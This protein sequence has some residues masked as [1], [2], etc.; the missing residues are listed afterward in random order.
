[1]KRKSLLICIFSII[2]SIGKCFATDDMNANKTVTTSDA[3]QIVLNSFSD[4]EYDIFQLSS[5][6]RLYRFFIDFEPK[7]GWEHNCA[8]FYIFKTYTGI[9]P[10]SYIEYYSLPPNENRTPLRINSIESSFDINSLRFSDLDLSTFFNPVSKHT[11]AIIL[12]GG[13]NKY[14]NYERYWNDCS[15]IY[16]TLTQRYCIPKSN[17]KVLMADGQDPAEDMMKRGKFEFISSPLDLDFDDLNEIEFAATRTNLIQIMT[18]FQNTLT[19]DDHLF[20]FV[21]D[22]GARYNHDNG[23]SIILW[24]DERFYD[25]EMKE[26]LIPLL[27]NSVTV[28]M[29]LGQCFS[30]GF[31]D[32]CSMGG[33]TIATACDKDEKSDECPD[34]PFDEF[35]YQW[36]SAMNGMNVS[37][38]KV[39]SDFDN[40]NHVTFLEAFEYAKKNDRVAGE[41]P[42]F[43]STPY[44]IGEN[45]SFNNI[46][47]SIAL[48]IRNNEEISPVHSNGIESINFLNGKLKINFR[49]IILNDCTKLEITSYTGGNKCIYD[50]PI[51]SRSIEI[52]SHTIDETSIIVVTMTNHYGII[53]SKTFQK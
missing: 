20:I 50:I 16:Q 1:M 17:I 22:H 6:P 4:E 31:I 30:G 43:S 11:Y 52:D 26:M 3:R 42:Q 12:S 47:Q 28:S 33:V 14:S 51:E 27:N 46:P 40:N 8:F 32:D 35:I 2:L 19:K 29:V 39:E 48:Y 18:D 36:I 25:Y 23:S 24:N 45:L 7:K 49:D 41:N 13:I 10:N 9:N 38:Q 37:G 21:T 5:T 15:Y 34:L 44:S 53:D